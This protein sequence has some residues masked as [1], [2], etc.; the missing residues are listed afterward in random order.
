[1]TRKGDAN[2]LM[3]NALLSAMI[4]VIFGVLSFLV[5]FFVEKNELFP[6]GA[7]TYYYLQRAEFIYDSITRDGI[8]FPTIDYSMYSG[9]ETLRYNAPL[10]VYIIAVFFTFTKSISDA[11]LIYVGMVAFLGGIVWV[12]IGFRLNRLFCGVIAGIIWFIVPANLY[13]LFMKGELSASLVISLMPLL[14]YNAD[15]FIHNKRVENIVAISILTALFTITDFYYAV[16]SVACLTF[17]LLIYGIF[18]RDYLSGLRSV[19]AGIIGMF[20][21]GIWLIPSISSMQNMARH[22]EAATDS[23]A[24]VVSLFNPLHR[25]GVNNACY[26]IGLSV[27]IIAL[28]GMIF[29]YKQ[30]SWYFVAGV[31]LII[32]SSNALLSSFKFFLH[33]RVT[34][35]YPIIPMAIFMTIYGLFKWERVRNRFL[36]LAIVLISLDVIPSMRIIYGNATNSG[37]ELRLEEVVNKNIINEAVGITHQRLAIVD[38]DKIDSVGPYAVS[39]F[40][41]KEA[42][43]GPDITIAA[44]RDNL[45]N[46]N[47]AL[48]EGKYLY[49]FDRMSEYGNDSVMIKLSEISEGTDVNDLN[50]SATKCGYRLITSDGEYALYRLKTEGRFGTKTVYSGIAIGTQSSQ[51]ARDFPYIKET[52]DGNI[53]HY[54]YDDLKDYKVIYLSGFTYD[55][56]TE[57][58]RLVVD[59]SE[60]GVKIIILADGIPEDRKSHN[61]SFLDVICNPI[62]FS[63]GYPLLDTIDG[64][65]DTDLF[66]MDHTSWSTVFVDGLDGVWGKVRNE[67]YDI[68]FY[69]YVNNENIVVIGLNL[70]YY[71]GITGDKLIGKL[72]AHSIGSYGRELP[73]REYIPL[74]VSKEGGNLVVISDEDNVNT[75]YTFHDTYVTD[76]GMYKDNNYLY[77]NKGKTVV[78]VMY[79]NTKA[80][81]AVSAVSFVLFILYALYIKRLCQSLTSENNND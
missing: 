44:N 9:A 75:T 46:L 72:L 63:N 45:I 27:L 24:D 20:T 10:S 25:L 74:S 22:N 23:F 21:Q 8:F 31:L 33:D 3:M 69:G 34:S 67:D 28:F 56:K 77:V 12:Y 59:L 73:D 81:I 2:R 37:N 17:V 51:I 4:V 29:S 50:T 16:I 55:D 61:Q 52:I 32:L 35:F 53:S 19:V 60:A 78:K 38:M 57:A 79:P 6:S 62:S 47:K 5:I 36:C 66:P 1:M 71:Y 14:F 48:T 15:M 39:S 42:A 54:S 58:E 76:N 26:Y 68:P 40:Y 11:Y 80:G 64:E 49:F 18:T 13:V 65:L 41:N 70:T 7:N 43:F 30:V